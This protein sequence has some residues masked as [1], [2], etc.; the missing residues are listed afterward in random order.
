MPQCNKYPTFEYNEH[1][2]KNID[3]VVAYLVLY[4]FAAHHYHRFSLFGHHHF[5][6]KMVSCIFLDRALVGSYD[7]LSNGTVFLTSPQRKK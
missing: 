6:G 4:H 7:P 3:P 2:Q 5:T 1:N